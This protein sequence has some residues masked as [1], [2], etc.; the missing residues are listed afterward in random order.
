MPDAYTNYLKSLD[1][2]H[3][4]LEVRMECDKLKTTNMYQYKYVKYT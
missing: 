2:K 3:G 1:P 4:V